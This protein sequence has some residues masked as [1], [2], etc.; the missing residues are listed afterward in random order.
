M[1]QHYHIATSDGS[2]TLCGEN[3]YVARSWSTEPAA[4]TCPKCAARHYDAL[5]PA[6]VTFRALEQPGSHKRFRGLY[7]VSISGEPR[8]FVTAEQGW[9]RGWSIR[10]FTSLWDTGEPI[11]DG[12]HSGQVDFPKPTE[13]R[14]NATSREFASRAM[15]VHYAL[16]WLRSTND[17]SSKLPERRTREQYEADKRLAV[18]LCIA[19][20]RADLEDTVKHC[21]ELAAERDA[22]AATM[23]RH[24]AELERL[25]DLIAPS[26]ERTA[27]I[28]WAIKQAEENA[29]GY[30]RNARNLRDRVAKAQEELK[31]LVS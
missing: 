23:R 2:A 31:G 13:K 5:I 15:A 4:V 14:P 21:G 12:T 9:D 24:V 8:F 28:E 29:D 27:A 20:K 10:P 1:T 11:V 3:E 7:E 16:T 30:E 17:P 18:E 26:T 19:Q 25:R 6:H 22:E